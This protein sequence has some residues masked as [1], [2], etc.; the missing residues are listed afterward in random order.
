MLRGEQHGIE[1]ADNLLEV[2]S[3]RHRIGQRELE[4]LFMGNHKAESE[5]GR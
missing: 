5:P 4:R 3:G 1:H 2:A